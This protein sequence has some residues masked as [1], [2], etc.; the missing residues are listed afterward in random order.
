MEKERCK[1]DVHDGGRWPSFHRCYLAAVK[2]GWCK[3]HHPL[4]E[5]KRNQ[6]G[7]KKRR[8]E[9]KQR[10]AIYAAAR[11]H[12]QRSS[13]FANLVAALGSL[14]DSREESVMNNAKEVLKAANK[15]L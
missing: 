9:W 3:I 6:A 2:D 14:I 1:K 5:K 10:E 11:L 15:F 13:L 7:E 4:A 12:Q 8:D